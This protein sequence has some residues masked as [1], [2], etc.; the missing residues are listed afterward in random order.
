MVVD[1]LVPPLIQ[2]TAEFMAKLWKMST[3]ISHVVDMRSQLPRLIVENSR[4]SA[5]GQKIHVAYLTPR[6]QTQYLH[7]PCFGTTHTEGVDH[8][9]DLNAT[10]LLHA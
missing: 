3:T 9:E 10:L 4:I 7:Q 5:G 6:P 1:R 2:D 8:L